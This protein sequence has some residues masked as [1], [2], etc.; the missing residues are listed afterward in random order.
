MTRLFRHPWLL[1]V[2]LTAASAP[3]CRSPRQEQPPREPEPSGAPGVPGPAGERSAGIPIGMNLCTHFPYDRQL[4][5]VDVFKSAGNWMILDRGESVAEKRAREARER[6]QGE[7][8]RK[9][10]VPM[11]IEGGY[12]ALASGQSLAGE[13]FQG[14]DGYF[15][16][17]DYVCTWKGTARIDFERGGRVKERSD[18]RLTVEVRP[19]AGSVVVRISGLDAEDPLRDV[20]LWMPG[21]EGAESPFYPPFVERLRPFRVIRYG[22]WARSAIGDTGPWEDRSTPESPTQTSRRGVALEYM[23]GLSNELGADAWFCM[24]HLA[25]DEYVRNFAELVKE[26]LHPDLKIY[27]EYSNETWNSMFP[28]AR[29]V[30]DQAKER[31]LRAPWVAA[32]EAARDWDV[33]YEVF[34]KDRDRIVRVAPGHLHNPYV[35]RE[36]VARLGD[37]VDAIAIATYFAIKA[38]R[39]DLSTKSSAAQVLAAARE[40][41]REIVFPRLEEHLRLARSTSER[42]GR[43]VPLITYEGGQHIVAMTT[44]G[45][46]DL[47]H[48]LSFETTV[49]CQQSPE[50]YDAYRELIDGLAARGV[51]LFMAYNYVGKRMPGDTFGHLEWVDQPLDQAPKY[52]A[53]V[54][55]QVPTPPR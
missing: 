20:H 4:P 17:G 28:Q 14:M 25:D 24:P 37:R 48:A 18:H 49:E 31:D 26:R 34:G 27:V 51:R 21:F 3:L 47:P 52:R 32:D 23:I 38:D 13:I 6:Q 39:N 5:F 45:R 40:N 30:M 22:H 35:A 41:L 44:L 29:W 12:P 9:R 2:L 50:M 11:D 16:G 43:D 55:E 42:L 46:P 54:D 7:N 53:L 33:W 36:Y 10:P 19:Q 1:G 15:P 8:R